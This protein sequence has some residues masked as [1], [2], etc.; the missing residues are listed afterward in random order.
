MNSK[1]PSLKGSQFLR[2]RCTHC[3]NCCTDTIVPVT[4]ADVL[5]LSRGTGLAAPEF[6]A[7]FGP[8]DFEHEEKELGW[9][10]LEEGTRV[11]ALAK[12]SE[13][14]ACVFFKDE[15]CSVDQHRPTTC[16]VYPFLLRFDRQG[17][18]RSLAIND[19]VECPFE[20]DSR[21]KL[22]EIVGNWR[23]DDR[24]D[25]AYFAKVRAWNGAHP[26][27]TRADFFRYLGL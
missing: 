2:F 18:P 17:K 26:G 15:R 25:E 5:R 12:Q 19:A 9:V 1:P 11:M 20:L 14:D 4:D 10:N 21:Q 22:A 7:F 23:L 3:G 16:R 24:Q 6:C 13:K 8:S 27:G